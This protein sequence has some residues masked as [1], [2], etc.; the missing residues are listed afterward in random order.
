MTILKERQVW[1]RPKPEPPK[2]CKT[3]LGVLSDEQEE[4]VR[5]A[6]GALKIRYGSLNALARSIR[7]DP[8]YLNLM[9]NGRRKVHPGLAICAAQVAGVP[10]DDVL[11]GKFPAEG[12]CPYCGRTG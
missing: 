5:R 6:L 1:K 3:R 12:A 10:V 9:F 2:V 11:T 4:G 8:T 7:V